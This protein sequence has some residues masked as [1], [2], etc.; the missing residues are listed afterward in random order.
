[1]SS[2]RGTFVIVCEDTQH[3]VFVRRFLR[4]SGVRNT[5]IR[6]EKSPAGLQ[7]ARQW[8]RRFLPGELRA[9]RNY[10][11]RNRS[12]NRML[13]VVSDA[14]NGTV[15][16]RTEYLTTE[17]DPKPGDQE[18]V[19]FVIPRWSVETWLKYLRNEGYDES[20]RTRRGDKWAK[21]R[22]CHRQ[23][24]ELKRMC[25]DRQLRSPAPPSLQMA[26][27]EFQRIRELL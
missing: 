27:T 23:V 10:N 11:A 20:E 18:K 26:C 19:C 24:D 4:L 8:I 6:V 3:E 2:P 14:D 16:E 25:D 5:S 17:C 13:I 1:M 15:E 22:D 21:A 12:A 7:D 9:F